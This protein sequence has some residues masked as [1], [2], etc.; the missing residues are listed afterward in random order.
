MAQKGSLFLHPDILEK[1]KIIKLSIYH[2]SNNN[3]ITTKKVFQHKTN[4]LSLNPSTS[5]TGIG[6]INP[7]FIDEKLILKKIKDKLHDKDLDQDVNVTFPSFSGKH[8][9][10]NDLINFKPI[11][12]FCKFTRK[13][14]HYAKGMSSPKEI[15]YTDINIS[16][17]S[18]QILTLV[19]FSFPYLLESIMSCISNKCGS[20]VSS[21]H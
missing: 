8:R 10:K 3:L 7:K 11:I 17:N 16:A 2:E 13:K 20:I 21:K 9:K 12:F 1:E 5:K 18:L 6:C 19:L 4:N 15:S 14:M